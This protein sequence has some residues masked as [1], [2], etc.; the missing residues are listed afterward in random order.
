M[1]EEMIVTIQNSMD[2]WT[3]ELPMHFVYT[4]RYKDANVT[5]G[6]FS[7]RYHTVWHQGAMKNCTFPFQSNTLAHAH[8]LH[9]SPSVRGQIHF[10]G[11]YRWN[12]W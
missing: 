8:G 2:K 6:F 3:A 7:A 4:G 11:L 5:I 9:H 12:L 10:N 1:E